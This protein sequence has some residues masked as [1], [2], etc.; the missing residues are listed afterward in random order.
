MNFK[1]LLSYDQVGLIY[2]DLFFITKFDDICEARQEF[3]DV[4]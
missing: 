3:V 1:K 2:D 4:G